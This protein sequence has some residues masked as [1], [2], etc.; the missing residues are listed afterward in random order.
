MNIVYCFNDNDK[1]KEQIMLLHASIISLIKNNSNVNIYIIYSYFNK[2]NLI[3]FKKFFNDYNCI[4]L[5]PFDIWF[6]DKINYMLKKSIPANKWTFLRLFIWEILPKSVDKVLYLD[7]DT[8][9]NWKLDELYAND[10][11]GKSLQV[12]LDNNKIFSR[13]KECQL[14][15]WNNTYFNA[16]IIYFN[17]EKIRSDLLDK[18]ILIF[19][20]YDNLFADQ[21]CLNIIFNKDIKVIDDKYNYIVDNPFSTNA[22]IYH[23]ATRGKILKINPVNIDKWYQKIFWQ[24]FDQTIYKEF[25][26]KFEMS[27][28]ITLILYKI[29]PNKFLSFLKN[30]SFYKKI[31][32][33]ISNYLLKINK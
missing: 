27:N 28:L 7:T 18:S 19:D 4:S 6:E 5:I 17:L 16:W 26:P 13:E 29:I 12:V 14:K 1:N 20:K 30:F 24:Y 21:D 22:K 2:T 8:I 15:L 9:I 3:E 32:H 33:K 23:F 11:N 10:F 31:M 25:R